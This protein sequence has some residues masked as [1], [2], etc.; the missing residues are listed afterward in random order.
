MKIAF[1]HCKELL[2]LGKSYKYD[3]FWERILKHIR[4]NIGQHFLG[5]I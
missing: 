1:K 2:F 3:I 4:N 5:Q